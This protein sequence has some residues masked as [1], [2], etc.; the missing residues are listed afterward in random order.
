MGGM[1]AELAHE[2]NQPLGAIVNFA[3]GTL[4]RLRA[5]GIDPEIEQAIAQI[6][7]EAFRA[8]EIIRRIRDFVRQGEPRSSA[9]TPTAGA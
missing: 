5:R 2:L 3:N 9:A 6:A 7:G 8:G 4:V 1:A